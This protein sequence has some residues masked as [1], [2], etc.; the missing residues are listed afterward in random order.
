MNH[1]VRSTYERF[2]QRKK[3]FNSKHNMSDMWV[4]LGDSWHGI[5]AK[6]SKI[7]VSRFRCAN[8][9]AMS[10]QDYISKIEKDAQNS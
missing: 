3:Y 5:Y 6:R 10:I 2:G 9:T 4:I 8:E 1:F 7:L